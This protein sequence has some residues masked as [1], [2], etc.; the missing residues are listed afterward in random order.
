MKAIEGEKPKYIT[1]QGVK[2]SDIVLD[3]TDIPD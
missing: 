3:Y 1:L 2:L